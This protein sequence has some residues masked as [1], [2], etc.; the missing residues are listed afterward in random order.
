MEFIDN[1]VKMSM[2]DYMVFVSM[3]SI[4]FIIGLMMIKSG[5]RK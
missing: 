5:V 1:I 2:T 4:T 3:I